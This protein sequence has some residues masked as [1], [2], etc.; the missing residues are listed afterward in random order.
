MSKNPQKEISASPENI[1]CWG[2]PE[3]RPGKE[4]MHV[5]EGNQI[6]KAGNELHKGFNINQVCG[7]SQWKILP[8]Y[9]AGN[10]CNIWMMGAPGDTRYNH[11]K[12][13]LFGLYFFKNDTHLSKHNSHPTRVGI[14]HRCSCSPIIESSGIVKLLIHIQNLVQLRSCTIYLTIMSDRRIQLLSETF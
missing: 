9:V 3:W 4:T 1:L 11:S 10:L 2:E 7:N 12:S 5:K 6:S 13:W 14:S 8:N